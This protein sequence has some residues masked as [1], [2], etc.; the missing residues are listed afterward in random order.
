MCTEKGVSIL[1]YSLE[2]SQVQVLTRE[3]KG[4]SRWNVPKSLLKNRVLE[5]LKWMNITAPELQ[6]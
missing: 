5:N 1:T 6:K 4:Y 3:K 2:W